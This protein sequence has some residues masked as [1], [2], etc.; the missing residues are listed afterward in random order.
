MENRF[1]IRLDKEVKRIS[2]L[3]DKAMQLAQSEQ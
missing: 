3:E 1:S 2:E